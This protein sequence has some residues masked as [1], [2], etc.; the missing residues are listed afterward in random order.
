MQMSRTPPRVGRQD[1]E[2]LVK[3]HYLFAL[4]LLQTNFEITFGILVEILLSYCTCCGFASEEIIALLSQ[5][6][7]VI[8]KL[9]F[10]F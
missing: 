3:N 5:S 9:Q 8:L 7:N 1:R 4:H 6:P 10:T 2:K